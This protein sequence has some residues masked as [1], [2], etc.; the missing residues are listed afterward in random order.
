MRLALYGAHPVVLAQLDS[1]ARYWLL[2]AMYHAYS[3][4][5]QHGQDETREYW[6]KAAAE[7]RI[8]T[9]KQPGR[10]FVKVWI[11]A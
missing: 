9:R 2:N 7:K 11:E 8:K 10:D 3:D 4:G 5:R 6:R 1:N